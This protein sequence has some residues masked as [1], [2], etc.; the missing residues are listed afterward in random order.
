M[1]SRLSSQENLEITGRLAHTVVFVT[2]VH[3][4]STDPTQPIVVPL[5]GSLLCEGTLV[6]ESPVG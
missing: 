2:V 5:G 4:V 3:R 6:G 1:Y